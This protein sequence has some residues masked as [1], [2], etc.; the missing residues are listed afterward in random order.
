VVV[1]SVQAT[2]SATLAASSS[3]MS[4]GLDWCGGGLG[5]AKIAASMAS[6]PMP[7]RIPVIRTYVWSMYR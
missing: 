2:R 7:A 3:L 5:C 6:A 1:V 4:V